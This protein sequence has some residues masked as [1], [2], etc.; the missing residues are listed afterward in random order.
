MPRPTY[1]LAMDTTRRRL[2]SARRCLA[3]SPFL[4]ALS[5]SDW[6]SAGISSPAAWS[7]ASCSLA[8]LPA[9]MAWASSI[10]SSEE[11]RFTLPISFRYMRTGSSVPKES[12][13]ELGSTISSSLMSSMASR[14]G[15]ASSG[16][17]GM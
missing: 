11:S 7:S 12:T 2:A 16:R 4:M 3:R 1:R 9:S 5:S 15:S 17:S 10:S 6:T 8:A 13:M 14:G